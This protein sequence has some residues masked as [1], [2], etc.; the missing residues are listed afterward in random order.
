MRRTSMPKKVQTALLGLLGLLGL[1]AVVLVAVPGPA[2]AGDD[3]TE[4][5]PRRGCEAKFEAAQ[6]ADM[7]SFR[8]YDA[9]TFRAVHDPDAVSIF[10]S[11]DRFVGV[12]AIMAALEGHFT[13]RQAIWSWTELDRRV[14]GCR[15]A[16]I[17]YET[18]YEIPRIGYYQRALTVVTYIYRAG[19]WLVIM[20]QGTLLEL[21]TGP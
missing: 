15:T 16:Y 5:A 11:G 17:E 1:L 3:T 14:V 6:R 2:M 20:D 8:D 9:V 10:P 7:E 18:V 4:S 12:E 21:R 19:H 13:D